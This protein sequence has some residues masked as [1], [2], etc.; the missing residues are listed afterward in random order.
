MRYK[1]TWT[2]GQLQTEKKQ[3]IVAIDHGLSFPGMP[4]L[5]DPISLLPRIAQNPLVDGII[6]TAGVYRQADL[7]GIDVS[8]LNRLITLDCVK[9]N[10][11]R[12]AEREIVLSPE[13]VMAYRPDCYKFFFNMYSDSGELMRNIR[14]ITKIASEGHRLGVSSLAEIMFWNCP[15]ADDPDKRRQLLYEGCR[16]AF[17]AGID[18]LKIPA[19][20][21]P[22]VMNQILAPFGLPTFIL[23]GSKSET[24]DAYF[25]AVAEMK[26][27]NI[28]G[29][30][31]GR[32]VWQSPDMDA[33]LSGI[34]KALNN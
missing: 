6:A 21:T 3:L 23:G 28:C 13:E 4:G 10:G 34:H 26:K 7:L 24:P 22:D 5:E 8:H 14:D 29:L 30:M 18:T 31:L 1:D 32:N 15:E 17:E 20:D 33:T 16:M 9:M 25:A 12:L 11:E 2:R 19:I 27:M